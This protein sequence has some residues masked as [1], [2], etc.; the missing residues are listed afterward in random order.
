MEEGV[1]LVRV[2]TISDESLTTPNK[3]YRSDLVELTH[4]VISHYFIQRAEDFRYERL[5]SRGLEKYH[6][7]LTRAGA[8]AMHLT[9]EESKEVFDI[10]LGRD[11]DKISEL[12]TGLSK[13]VEQVGLKGKEN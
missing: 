2:A 4:K 11:K 6:T 7:R 1:I 3:L 8:K 9:P 13:R 12:L 5:N 10:I